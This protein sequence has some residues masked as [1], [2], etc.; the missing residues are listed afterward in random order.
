MGPIYAYVGME[1]IMLICFAMFTEYSDDLS[2][3]NAG[4]MQSSQ[5]TQSI[6]YPYF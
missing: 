3:S 5:F 1:L 4:F 6:I 2:I